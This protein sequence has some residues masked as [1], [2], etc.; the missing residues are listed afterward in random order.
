MNLLTW[1]EEP[2]TRGNH[3][4]CDAFR[5]ALEA[6]SWKGEG[7]SLGIAQQHRFRNM[8]TW[9]SLHS[10]FYGVSLTRAFS[11]G[12][13]H[14]YYDGPHCSLS[15]GFLHILWSGNPLT[16]WCEKCMPGEDRA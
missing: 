13:D 3:M 2:E 14:A 9:F 1:G 8:S 6:N 7:A 10:R 5:W 15:L 11:F 12:V 16:G 4:P